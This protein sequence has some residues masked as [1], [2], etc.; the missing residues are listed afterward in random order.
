MYTVLH[1]VDFEVVQTMP[2]AYELIQVM[3][4]NLVQPKA[5][6]LVK[7]IIEHHWDKT[8]RHPFYVTNK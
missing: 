1:I 2:F 5:K 3:K 4:E 7:Q 8:L 6:E